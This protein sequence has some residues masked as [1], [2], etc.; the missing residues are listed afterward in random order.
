MPGMQPLPPGMPPGPALAPPEPQTTPWAVGTQ[1]EPPGPPP[2]PPL[3]PPEPHSPLTQPPPPGSCGRNWTPV[4]G[5][6][7]KEVASAAAIGVAP[8]NDA[9]A[10]ATKNVVKLSFLMRSE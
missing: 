3:A 5:P 7:A 1:P 10:P 2:G 8:I 6:V 9:T 4:C